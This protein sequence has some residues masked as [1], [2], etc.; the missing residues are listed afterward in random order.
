MYGYNLFTTRAY[1]DSRS[2]RKTFIKNTE[3]VAD[4]SPQ[5]KVK[6]CSYNSGPYLS[7]RFYS[8]HGINIIH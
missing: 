2:A 8:I 1:N 3:L 6:N 4:L 7:A 5:P